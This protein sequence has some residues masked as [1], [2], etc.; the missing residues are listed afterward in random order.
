MECS[1]VTF[2]LLYI[3]N[4]FLGQRRN[5]KLAKEWAET[6]LYLFQKNF[7][8]VGG[9]GFLMKLSQSSYK[10]SASGRIN[11][12]GLES[13]LELCNRHDLVISVWEFLTSSYDKVIIDV[14]MELEMQML[15]FGL[16]P[17]KIAQNLKN[18]ENLRDILALAKRR[19]VDGPVDFLRLSVY[20]DSPEL[21]SEYLP[22]RVVNVRMIVKG[23]L[24]IKVLLDLWVNIMEDNQ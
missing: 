24:G 22:E 14:A 20:S 5:E 15:V 11:C 6:Y 12:I 10:T 18:D 21:V 2:F 16:I 8:K 9:E 13:T 7:A 1:F 23:V 3:I 4:F 17:T 19:N